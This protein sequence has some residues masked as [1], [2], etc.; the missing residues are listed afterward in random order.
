MIALLAAAAL[1]SG[2]QA[3]TGRAPLPAREVERA[4][5]LP[6]GWWAVDADLSWKRAAGLWGMEGQRLLRD[7]AWRTTRL[8][9]TVRHGLGRSVELGA[10]VPWEWATLGEQRAR[11]IGD[12]VI[13]GRLALV[14]EEPPAR[15]L[16]LELRHQAPLARWPH[17]AGAAVWS[18]G[19]IGRVRHGGLRVEA[20]ARAERWTAGRLREVPSRYRGGGP[21]WV[22][23]GDR[24]VMTTEALYQVG[25]LWTALRPT[26]IRR[27]PLQLG[28][29]PA[30]FPAEDYLPE[31]EAGAWTVDLGSSW[32]AQLTRGWT[33]SGGVSGS[34]VGAGRAFFPTEA[35]HPARGR[36]WR[37]GVACRL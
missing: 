34:V 25:P 32:G 15:S 1:A 33:V 18:A 28:R 36:T 22:K 16:A 37:V 8:A 5:V 4:V 23:P 14:R 31:V 29:G 26:V 13:W 2:L 10:Q 20:A 9:S 11:T 7:P 19:L 24:W 30:V 17:G 27:G 21:Y 12:P 35:I 3:R 6:R